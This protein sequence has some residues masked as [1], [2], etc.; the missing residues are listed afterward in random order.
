MPCLLDPEARDPTLLVVQGSYSA[1]H[2]HV[3]VFF[4]GSYARKIEL[5]PIKLPCLA[6]CIA[7]CIG[8]FN[9]VV[10]IM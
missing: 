1:V 8:S 4:L 10:L 3:H 7:T 2:V 6:T 9:N 5:L